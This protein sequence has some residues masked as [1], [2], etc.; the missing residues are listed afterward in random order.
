LRA[1]WHLANA[2]AGLALGDFEAALDASQRDMSVNPDF[3]TCYLTGAAAA[4]R[5][6]VHDLARAW[7]G[8]LRERT[9]FRTLNAV[10]DRLPPA[11]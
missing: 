9:V 11:T 8:H 2:W 3:A 6:G 10:R 1:V 5:C 4:Q 7:V